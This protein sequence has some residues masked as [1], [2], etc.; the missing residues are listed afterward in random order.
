MGI[1]RWKLVY[2]CAMRVENPIR[3]RIVISSVG[4]GIGDQPLQVLL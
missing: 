4:V 3:T 1:R 2:I